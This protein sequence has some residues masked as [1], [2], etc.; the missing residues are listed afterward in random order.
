MEVDRRLVVTD[1]GMNNLQLGADDV[2]RRGGVPV[3]VDRQGLPTDDI[4]CIPMGSDPGSA[5]LEVAAA[6]HVARPSLE[7]RQVAAWIA[8]L[9]V[10]QIKPD[11]CL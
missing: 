4:I 1:R 8:R 11:H 9:A 3:D 10:S 2:V 5:H 6:S 7:Q